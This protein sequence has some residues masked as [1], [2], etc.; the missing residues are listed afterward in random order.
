[1]S[2]WLKKNDKHKG[3][4][5]VPHPVMYLRICGRKFLMKFNLFNNLLCDCVELVFTIYHPDGEEW[6]V[7]KHQVHNEIIEAMGFDKYSEIIKRSLLGYIV[8]NSEI[9][10]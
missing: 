10:E 8:R 1:M 5:Q 2:D 7:F 9:I 4:F 3:P 6:I